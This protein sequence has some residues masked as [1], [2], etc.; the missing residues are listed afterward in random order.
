MI[1]LQIS[2]DFFFFSPTSSV[3]VSA[4]NRTEGSYARDKSLSSFFVTKFPRLRQFHTKR[5]IAHGEVAVQPPPLGLKMTDHSGSVDVYRESY[6]Y[7]PYMCLLSSFFSA[8]LNTFVSLGLGWRMKRFHD[9]IFFGCS[10]SST[11]G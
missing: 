9:L 3:Q 4:K 2:F 11:V 6:E 7:F 1:K 10:P 8:T 5:L